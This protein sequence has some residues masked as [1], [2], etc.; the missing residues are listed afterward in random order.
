MTDYRLAACD[1]RNRGNLRR[2]MDSLPTD[3]V[4]NMENRLDE[5]LP[6]QDQREQMI[7]LRHTK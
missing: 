2:A 1:H 5:S 3:S 4:M 6:G 7:M